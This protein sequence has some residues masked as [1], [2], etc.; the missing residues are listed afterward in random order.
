[1]TLRLLLLADTHW[2]RFDGWA[3]ARGVDVVE[4]EVGRLAHL[5][6]FWATEGAESE[7]DLRKFEAQLWV[8]PAGVVPDRGPWS[9]EEENRAFAALKSSIGK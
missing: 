8:P 7:A 1:V 6:Q 3:W 9:P 4:L 2:T 5:V